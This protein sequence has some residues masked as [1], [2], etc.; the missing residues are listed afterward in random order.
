MDFSRRSRVE[1]LRESFLDTHCAGRSGPT[2]RVHFKSDQEPGCV[3]GVGSGAGVGAGGGGGGVLSSCWQADSI[4]AETA[5]AQITARNFR[6]DFIGFFLTLCLSLTDKLK[7][8][9]Q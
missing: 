8:L 5:T 4:T 3:A 9:V 7:A 1:G 2:Q 6:W